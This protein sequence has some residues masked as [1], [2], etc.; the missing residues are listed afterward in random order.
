MERLQRIL[1]AR[2]VASR[3]AAEELITAGRVSVD[4]K[5]VTE[6]GTRADP[7]RSTIRVDGKLLKVQRPRYILLNKP[8]GYITTT[9]DERDRRT[10]MDLVQV[11][12]RVYPVGRLDRDTE[13]L[14][15]LTNDGD[16][17]NRVMHPR[18]GLEKEYHV[19]TLSRPTEATLQ[20]LRA[21]VTIEGKRI[22]PEEIRIQRET[23]EGLILKAVVHEGIHHLVR[24]MMDEVGIPVE[25][26]RRVRL[27]PLSVSGI[28]PGVWRELSHGELTTL[29]EALHLDQ[30]NESGV[31]VRT[32]RYQPA[33]PT[34]P[35]HGDRARARNRY[36][37][38]ALG[39][40]GAERSDDR[41]FDRRGVPE[42]SDREQGRREDVRPPDQRSDRPFHSGRADGRSSR[43]ERNR[44]D[45]HPGRPSRDRRG[46]GD[47]ENVRNA[48]ASN[49]GDRGPEPTRRPDD[50]KQTGSPGSGRFEPRANNDRPERRLDRDDD[51]RGN[52][53]AGRGRGHRND[54]DARP[55]R[56]EDRTPDRERSSDRNRTTSE[57]GNPR[58]APRRPQQLDR[59]ER[60]DRNA[61]PSGPSLPPGGP[62]VPRRDYR[63]ER[64]RPP[65]WQ[66]RDRDEA[67]VNNERRDDDRGQPFEGNRDRRPGGVRE[68]KRGTRSRR[69]RRRDLP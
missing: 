35:I 15:L 7:V 21:G 14:L 49:Q 29:L 6:L 26:L 16:V 28:Q 66:N 43:G 61:S 31:D 23:A 40:L 25:R 64:D 42:R 58:R 19:L 3:R 50:R 67:R 27:G 22:V 1:A 18:Y 33:R 13:G 8:R 10:V 41:S 45:Q 37:D 55:G 60:S 48:R 68:V 65:R 17:A 11:P 20:R 53:D 12:E 54:R 63:G 9:K 5:V 62:S 4:G 52:R 36:H 46:N 59:S 32:A 56:F 47:P 69:P 2:G 30:A 57:H 24:R 51:R 44:G 34:V 38:D 39:A